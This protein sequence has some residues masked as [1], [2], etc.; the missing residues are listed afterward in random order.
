MATRL[1][2][3]RVVQFTYTGQ[4]IYMRIAYLSPELLQCRGEYIHTK[5]AE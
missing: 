4:F 1:P 5:L 3:I 2:I